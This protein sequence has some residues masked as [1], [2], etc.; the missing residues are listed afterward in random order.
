[1]IDSSKAINAYRS[2][3]TIKTHFTNPD[4]DYRKKYGKVRISDDTF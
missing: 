2:Y 4:F 1:M 3:V